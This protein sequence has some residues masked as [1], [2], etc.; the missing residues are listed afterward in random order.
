MKWNKKRLL[1]WRKQQLRAVLGYKVNE[2]CTLLVEQGGVRPRREVWPRA[3]GCNGCGF[4]PAASEEASWNK[5]GY[6]REQL[7]SASQRA[8]LRFQPISVLW[9][10]QVNMSTMD[11]ERLKMSGAGRAIAVLTSGGDAQGDLKTRHGKDYSALCNPWVHV[12]IL[13]FCFIEINA[14]SKRIL[15]TQ[16]CVGSSWI[17]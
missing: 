1:H 3:R 13:I 5:T 15:L 9:G 7:S 4:E 6:I 12:R 2:P 16:R 11:M 14:N 10:E 17:L 8:S